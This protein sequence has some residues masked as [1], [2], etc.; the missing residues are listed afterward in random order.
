MRNIIYAN[1]MN[2]HIK[3]EPDDGITV[4][5]YSRI[6]QTVVSKLIRLR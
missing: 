3:H 4:N 5:L 2:H 6:D 1:E